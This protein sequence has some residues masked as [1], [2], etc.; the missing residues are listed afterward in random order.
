M[1]PPYDMPPIPPN[2]ET[3]PL[4]PNCN[5]VLHQREDDKIDIIQHRFDVYDR[6]TE[7]VIEFYRSRNMLKSFT[8]HKG[9]KD[10]D[11]LFKVMMAPIS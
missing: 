10:A 11:A 5:P 7:P 2:P 8:V 4:R 3:C 9:V 6:E 1:T